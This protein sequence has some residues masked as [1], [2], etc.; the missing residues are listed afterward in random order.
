MLTVDCRIK[1]HMD[2]QA[3]KSLVVARESKEIT[4]LESLDHAYVIAPNKIDEYRKANLIKSNFKPSL[5]V[6]F[7]R[8]PPFGATVQSQRTPVRAG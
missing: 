8:R 7:W 3:N 5:P 1:V 2:L 6:R 4:D